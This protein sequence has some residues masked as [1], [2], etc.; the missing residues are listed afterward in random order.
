[1]LRVPISLKND[2]YLLIEL[3]KLWNIISF[4]DVFQVNCQEN[5]IIHEH[6]D[7][8]HTKQLPIP[9]ILVKEL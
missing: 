8:S 3:K 6:K 9:I 4:I 7:N 1:M 2:M 5:S